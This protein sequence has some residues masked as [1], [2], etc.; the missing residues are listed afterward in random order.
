MLI[1]RKNILKLCVM[2]C[3]FIR[4]MTLSETNL[5]RKMVPFHSPQRSSLEAV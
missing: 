1:R 5:L 2:Y 4:L 3:F